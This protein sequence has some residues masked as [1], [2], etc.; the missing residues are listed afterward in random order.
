MISHDSVLSRQRVL[1][2]T[3][4]NGR[5]NHPAGVLRQIDVRA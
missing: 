1:A 2:M 5:H 3:N 4:Q